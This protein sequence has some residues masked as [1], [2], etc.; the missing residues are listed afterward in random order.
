M[1]EYKAVKVKWDIYLEILNKELNNFANDGWEVVSVATEPQKTMY[2][3]V[4]LCREV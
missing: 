2:F 1:K 4:T 3:V